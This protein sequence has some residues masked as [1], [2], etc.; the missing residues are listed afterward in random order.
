MTSIAGYRLLIVT[1]R[2]ILE[3]NSGQIVT[4]R[5]LRP[6]PRFFHALDINFDY[7]GRVMVS[8]MSIRTGTPSVN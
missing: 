4:K 8:I 6:F 5:W 7:R 3:G 2:V 1:K